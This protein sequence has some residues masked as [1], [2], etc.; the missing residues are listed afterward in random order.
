MLPSPATRRARATPLTL[1]TEATVHLKKTSLLA[2]AALA[3]L[4]PA[5]S[6]TRSDPALAKTAA[7]VDELSGPV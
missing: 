4:G 3:S 1:G 7:T 2:M 5:R 6:A